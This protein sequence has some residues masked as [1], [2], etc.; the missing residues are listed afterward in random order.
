MAQLLSALP[1]GA[2][3]K[4]INTK[5]NGAVIRW[6]VGHH[7]PDH[8]K[9]VTEKIISLKC[10]DAKESSNPSSVRQDSGNNRYSQSNIDQWLNS[11]AGAGVWYSARHSYDKPPSN[12]YVWSNYNEYDAE[13][14][15]LA[16]FEAK[17][18][19]ALLDDAITIAL[20][21]YDGGGS[22]TITRKIRLLTKTEVGLGTEN[23]ITEGTV[24]SYFNSTTR[25]LA[26]PTA[27]AVSQ[28]ECTYSDLAPSKPYYYW[29]AT[30][31]AI[32]SGTA[33]TVSASGSL[34]N[35][36]DVYKGDNGLRPAL[37]LA[38][39]NL[40]SDAPDT[41]GAY[42]LVWNQP[43]TIPS[44]ISHGIPYAGQPLA[45]TT[46]GST[47]PDGDTI[48]YVWERKI[49]NG[50]YAQIGITA[51]T[52]YTD[53]VPSSGTTYQV[54]VKAVDALG[55]ESAYT[56]GSAVAIN[57][58]TPPVI[59]GINTTLGNQTNPLQYVYTVTDA[60]AG[61][62]L[63]V[64][65][66]VTNGGDLIAVKTYTATSG[67]QYTADLT[68]V[69]L[70]LYNGQHVLTITAN[71]GAGGMV[72]RQITF[73]RDL[74]RI[75]ASRAVATDSMVTKCLLSLFPSD[76]PSDSVF[77]CEVTNNPFDP[78]PIWEDATSKINRLTHTFVNTTA[79]NGF[80]VAYRF[81]INKG[82]SPIEVIQ[83]SLRFS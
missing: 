47:D 78:T 51:V 29:L 21:T 53:I 35:N 72:T 56:T 37:F 41:D 62:T 39:D 6:I 44:S 2:V 1:V 22:E 27:E 30:P 67:S 59:S 38:S 16:N 64:T 45:I 32:H 69:W 12:T 79:S 31:V 15:F 83:A 17:F 65:E 20:P 76:R 75:A 74:S 10:F 40:V 3:V 61:Q 70:R 68:P 26:Y 55:N 34:G 28:S 25:R 33:R 82:V 19:N 23:G 18:C 81:Y 60:D 52:S 24:W 46:G 77:Y 58:N 42:I 48:S 66:T 49:D 43:P 4:S 71:D 9:L 54:R 13:V 5:Y 50:V 80:G 73:N 11:S 14:G 8:V 57:Y 63:T 7:E 36:D